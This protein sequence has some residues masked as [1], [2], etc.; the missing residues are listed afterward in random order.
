MSRHTKFARVTFMLVFVIA[1]LVFGIN[2]AFAAKGQSSSH[3]VI[4]TEFGPT[5]VSLPDSSLNASTVPSGSITTQ[6]EIGGSDVLTSTQPISPREAIT[7]TTSIDSVQGG[8]FTLSG[9]RVAVDFA[10]GAIGSD[11]VVSAVLSADMTHSDVQFD[12]HH[13]VAD[14]LA[15]PLIAFNLYPEMTFS[16]PVTV[17]VN[18]SGLLANDLFV[19]GMHPVL[20]YIYTEAVTQSITQ[21]DGSAKATLVEYG[22]SQVIPSQ[23]DGISGILVAQ[24]THFSSYVIVTEF[25]PPQVWKLGTNLGGVNL[26]GG[27]V[28][29]SYPLVAP[30]MLDNLQPQLAL[31]YSSAAADQNVKDINSLGVGWTMAISKI[32]QGVRL[33]K[34]NACTHEYSTFHRGDT[35]ITDCNGNVGTCSQDTCQAWQAHLHGYADVQ[36]DG[37]YKLSFQGRDYNLISKGSGEYVTE[38]YAPLRI[39]LCAVNVA[40]NG[41][42]AQGTNSSGYYW[43]V[44]TLDGTVYLFGSDPQSEKYFSSTGCVDY[45]NRLAAATSATQSWYIRRVYAAHRDNYSTSPGRWSVEYGYVEQPA[46]SQGFDCGTYSYDPE[47]RLTQILYGNSQRSNWPTP[48]YE[49]LLDYIT[50][51][52]DLRQPITITSRVAG[53]ILSRYVLD[54]NGAQNLSS[55]RNEVLNG[56]T[57]SS[58]PSTT[59]Y[60]SSSLSSNLLTSVGNNYGGKQTYAYGSEPY[61]NAYRRVLTRTLENGSGWSGTTTYSYQQPCFNS[62]G[63]MCY[64]GHDWGS[65]SN[66]LIG[67]G[68]VTETARNTA[69]NLALSVNAHRFHIDKQRSGLEFETRVIDPNRSDSPTNTL[70]LVQTTYG[71]FTTNV[72]LM[73]NT[74]FA[75]PIASVTYPSGDG[76]AAIFYYQR[77]E[78]TYDLALQGGAFY[79]QATGIKKYDSG[80]LI[81]TTST[82]YAIT[83]TA[84]IMK[85]I[86]QTV[87]DASGKKL[88]EQRS[89]FDGYGF[90]VIG[91]KG[92]LTFVQDVSDTNHTRDV[93]IVYD[94]WGNKT[95]ESLFTIYGTLGSTN[96]GGRPT[97]THRYSYAGDWGTFLLT[98]TNPLNQSTRYIYYC[99]NESGG[100][101]TAGQPWGA[102]KAVRD[103]NSDDSGSIQTIYKYDVFGRLTKEI[104][105]YDSDAYPTVEYLYSLYTGGGLTGYRIIKTTRDN[106]GTGNNRPVMSFYDGL[107]RLVQTRGETQE[108]YQVAVTNQSYDALGRQNLT[109]VPIYVG[110]STFGGY[111]FF[112]YQAP[113][114]NTITKTSTTYDALGRPVFVLNADGTS[115]SQVY[116]SNYTDVIDQKG[117]Y[118]RQVYDGFGKL[119]RVVDPITT[120][121]DGFDTIS[122]TQWTPTQSFQTIVNGT[123]QNT[124]SANQ[125]ESYIIRKSFN[126]SSTLSNPSGIPQAVKFDFKVTRPSDGRVHFMLQTPGTQSK[127]VAVLVMDNKLLMQ[128][129]VDGVN[130]Q[131]VDLLTGVKADTWYVGVIRVATVNSGTAGWASVE[132]W[133]RDNPANRGAASITDPGLAYA[134]YKFEHTLLNGVS[135][136]DNYQEFGLWP[137]DYQYDANDQLI[138]T[139]DALG[140][141]TVITYDNWG[142]KVGMSD[143]D[144]GVWSYGYDLNG[145]L[146]TQTDARMQTVWFGYDNLNRL[147]QKRQSDASGQLL[148]S[149]GYDAQPYGIG[150]RTN[151]TNASGSTYWTYDMR[152]RV[153]NEV[154][155]LTNAGTYTTS[156]AY[157]ASDRVVSMTYPSGEIVSTGYDAGG[158][159]TT[160]TG[161][162]NYV[163]GATYNPLGA[164]TQVNYG[165]NLKTRYLYFGMEVPVSGQVANYYYGRL[166]RICVLPQASTTDCENDGTPPTDPLLNVAFNY[167]KVGNVTVF[168]D[169]TPTTQQKL[170]YNYDSLDRLVGVVPDIAGV[171]GW[172]NVISYFT[173]S[174]AYDAIGNITNFSGTAYTYDNAAHKHAVTYFGADQRYWYDDNGNMTQRVEVSGTQRITYTQE[175]DIDNRLVAVT[176]T[177]SGLVTAYTYD[178]DGGRVV[179][180]DPGGSQ[181]LYLAGGAMEVDSRPIYGIM[182]GRPITGTIGSRYVAPTG[183][184]EGPCNQPA[185]PCRTVQY[186]HDSATSGDSILL[187]AGT[188][189]TTGSAVLSATKSITIIGGLS[190]TNW[191]TPEP[192]ANPTI[193]SGQGVRR[194]LYID[195][196]ASVAIADLTIADGYSAP[197]TQSRG[198]GIY[199]AGTLILINVAVTGNTAYYGCLNDVVCNA[200]GG[201]IYSTGVLFLTGVTLSGNS[202]LGSSH[203]EGGGIYSSG[204]AYLVN[205]TLSGNTANIAPAMRYCVCYRGGGLSVNAST[206]LT[207]VTFNGNTINYMQGGR[208]YGADLYGPATMVNTIVTY[209]ADGVVSQGHNVVSGNC[210]T[211]N[212]ADIVAAPLLGALANNGGYVATRALQWGSPAINTGESAACPATDARWAPREVEKCDIGAYEFNGPYTVTVTRTYYAF[213]SMQVALRVTGEPISST[214]GLFYLQGD[215]QGSASLTTNTSGVK[216]SETRYYPFGEVRWSSGTLPTDRT[217][218][219]QRS[220]SQSAVGSLMDYGARFYSP[221][222]GRFISADSIVPQPG[223]PQSMNR[224]SYVLNSALTRIDPS[225]H[226]DCAAGDNACWVDQWMWKNRWYEA[227][228][229]FWNGNGWTFGQDANGNP[230]HARF[231]DDQIRQDTIWEAGI[232]FKAGMYT[233]WQW[234][235]KEMDLAAQGIVDF[236]HKVGGLS[237]LKSLLGGFATL[238]RNRINLGGTTAFVGGGLILQLDGFY[239]NF[240]GVY[241]ETFSNGDDFARGTIVHE[242]AHVI[243]FNNRTSNG[244]A[245]SDEFPHEGTISWYAVKDK[246][247]TEY[248]AEGVAQWVYY[249]WR[250]SE[251]QYTA[252]TVHQSNWLAG[253][254]K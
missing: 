141:T 222:L 238:E 39:W 206:W 159:P 176:N 138:G 30:S 241:D 69:D 244:R 84:W 105:P 4:E 101:C 52:A 230:M 35:Y 70:Q 77:Q 134:A 249:N 88:S 181:T 98:Y 73:A 90:G 76:P 160:L 219:G 201:G 112:D 21:P 232:R 204:A 155:A 231:A 6:Q 15:S 5:S 26:Y 240:V 150:H 137:T 78:T 186:A 123:L 218:T 1:G 111:P 33:E 10:P 95:Q 14:D 49:L 116:W 243:D 197:D 103:P 80:T 93:A 165:N 120:F 142:H 89:Y 92:D 62:S 110:T 214:N 193:L 132:V 179:R 145:N 68:W 59:F 46:K 113:D 54:Y 56:N 227:H 162:S 143:L 106:S 177:V 108:G 75:A 67:Y 178:A 184:D 126:I 20:R 228:G 207:N 171:P 129:S 190:T 119:K 60:Y 109:S 102:L 248:F 83:T 130:L 117:Y 251:P 47:N 31:E 208:T 16:A 157:D 211:G 127:R 192:V 66:A 188:Y 63:A 167:D 53:N 57:P 144:M 140:N 41:F 224:Y 131:A 189:T 18:L 100:I 86:S 156:Y 19:Q 125:Y 17:T 191:L 253:T 122:T 173:S 24:L 3:P 210:V 252:L 187:A 34:N 235:P 48:Q 96:A 164:L 239:Q 245:F 135:Y 128:T 216:V 74:W 42:P 205:V 182:E 158:R 79:G 7:F 87:V 50:R 55:V 2:T 250:I 22:R 29:Y 114:W 198:G 81:N 221:A 195:S 215:H 27:S 223:N 169:A 161:A 13:A 124:A 203:A 58:L 36:S 229:S 153:R 64:T 194:G 209:C 85:P 234:T 196:S 147:T 72:G 212:G 133:E 45:G 151:M 9:A 225:G 175:W 247:S 25:R 148:A 200:Y 180:H 185:Y 91:S 12:D 202:A 61:N 32:S 168:R 97:Q 183:V 107:G 163:T 28:N 220:E 8:R 152:G 37:D 43:Q 65:P 154:Q 246:K 71:V 199:N 217:F 11:K 121:E 254:L 242:L 23:Y 51:T 115:N 136:M 99:I 38:S 174:Y 236:A 94:M 44:W 139:T 233:L 40:C 237:I 118:R 172:T 166:R 149:Y 213:G 82:R 170:V 104:Q 226:G 146:T